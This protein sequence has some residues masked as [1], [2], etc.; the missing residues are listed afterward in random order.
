MRFIVFMEN[1]SEQFF[2]VLNYGMVMRT[3]VEY[4]ALKKK[5]IVLN[6]SLKD[7]EKRV[8]QVERVKKRLIAKQPLHIV[9]YFHLLFFWKHESYIGGL[10]SFETPSQVLSFYLY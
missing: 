10:R 6:A 2:A 3:I 4:R 1:C 8:E 5:F 7:H 9:K